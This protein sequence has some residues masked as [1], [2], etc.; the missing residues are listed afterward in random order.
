LLF[1]QREQ[2]ALNALYARA[3]RDEAHRGE[4]VQDLITDFEKMALQAKLSNEACMQM[5]AW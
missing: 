1:Q 2:A 4:S 5:F 3:F